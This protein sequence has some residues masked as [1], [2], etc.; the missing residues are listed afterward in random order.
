MTKIIPVLLIVMYA[1]TGCTQ[2]SKSINH[3]ESKSTIMPTNPKLTAENYLETISKTVKHFPEEPYYFLEIDNIVGCTY[4]IY[5]NDF[6]VFKYYADGQV[7]A[8]VDIQYYMLKNGPQKITYKLY[9]I[10]KRENG[11]V[12]PTLVDWTELK[13]KLLTIDKTKKDPYLSKK[14]LSKFHSPTAGDGHS[15]IAAGQK[16]YENSFTFDAKLP[17]ENKYVS[18]S[19]DLSKMDQK[20]LLQKTVSAYKKI[21]QLMDERKKDEYF[22]YLYTKEVETSQSEYSSKDDL[23]ESLNAYLVPFDNDTF[24]MEPLENYKMKLY[25]NGKIVCLEQDTQDL[26]AKGKSALWGKYKDKN[27]TLGSFYGLYL[28]IPEGKTEF[29]II[30]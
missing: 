28:H 8:Q 18:N 17:F 30:R 21:W 20:E 12:I 16:Y 4:E 9:P 19:T 2:S 25:A 23:Q 11:D 29:E 10:G 15:F 14:L 6:P 27:H 1:F 22:N 24:K 7:S 13:L 5:L 26:R 3:Q